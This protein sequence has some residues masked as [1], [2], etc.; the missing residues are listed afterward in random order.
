MYVVKETDSFINDTSWINRFGKVVLKQ[1]QDDAFGYGERFGLQKNYDKS[2]SWLL[3]FADGNRID[4][5]VETLSA[6]KSGINRNRLSIALVDKQNCLPQMSPT[7]AD[8]YVKKPSEKQFRGC[9]NEFY[10]CLCDVAKG[11]ARDELPFAMTTYNTLVRDMLEIMLDWYIG[12]YTD[13]SVSV[14][15]LNKYF[16]KYLPADFY[17][18]YVETYTDSNYDH[19]WKSIDAACKLFRKAA[20]FVAERSA[21]I[22]PENDEYASKRYIQSIRE[23]IQQ[24][25]LY[26]ANCL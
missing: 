12:T 2:Y 24:A 25:H 7:D 19:F 23:R 11:I 8:F 6:M 15:K 13:Y 3:L 4:I 14:G 9:C 20:L 5:G 21:F 22:Y 17:E 26:P 10:W 16:K 18:Q 1:E